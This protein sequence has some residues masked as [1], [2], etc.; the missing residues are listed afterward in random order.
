MAQDSRDELHP[1][2][3]S[4]VTAE[5]GNHYCPQAKNIAGRT[6]CRRPGADGWKSNP[7]QA[8]LPEGSTPIQDVGCAASGLEAIHVEGQRKGGDEETSTLIQNKEA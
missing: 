3:R 1:I 8:R 4:E 6:C 2:S 7:A 5:K